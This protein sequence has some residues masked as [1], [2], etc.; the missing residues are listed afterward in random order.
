VTAASS[1]S[2]HYQAVLDRYQA[3]RRLPSLV[4][5]VLDGGELAWSGFAGAP[6]TT[7]TQYRI[8]SITKTLTAVLVMQCRDDGLLDL[9]DPIGTHVPETGYAKAS[10]ESLLAHVSGMQSEPN[11]PWWERS[12]GTSVDELLSLNDASGAVFGTRERY[13]YSNLGFGLLG[14][15]VARLRG[16]SWMSLIQSRILDPLG[17]SRTSYLPEEPH[18]QGLSVHHLAGTLTP[19]PAYDAGAMAPAGQLWS[20]I[21]D[22]AALASFVALG[23]PDVLADETLAQMRRAVEPAP[24]YGLGI[25]LVPWAGGMLAGHTGSMPG[26]QAALFADPLTH[27]GVVAL[28]SATTGFSGTELTQALLG[29]YTPGPGAAWVPTVE[30]P[31]WARELL[32]YWHWG[33]SAYEVRWTNDQLEWRD[34]ARSTTAETFGHDG[35]RIL[36]TAGYHHGETLHVVRNDDGSIHHLDC[37]TFV[38]TRTPYPDGP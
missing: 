27:V 17:M 4:V 2:S 19:E 33:N 3:D 22:L 15:A 1:R 35:D 8:G 12:P 10:V 36:G 32:G 26:F 13:H 25:R 24:D 31:E 38:Y 20:T 23:N 29:G 7:D 11:G 5:G 37:A 14:E 9:D 18:A 28:T 34:L 6:T 21:E 30:V 16:E